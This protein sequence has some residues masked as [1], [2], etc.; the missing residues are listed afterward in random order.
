MNVAPNSVGTAHLE[1]EGLRIFGGVA[2]L[3]SQAGFWGSWDRNQYSVSAMAPPMASK[4]QN[5]P[6]GPG[7][8]RKNGFMRRTYIRPGVFS[9]RGFWVD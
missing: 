2:P 9:N 3:L 5:D 1:A 8:N 7:P 6:A 4:N